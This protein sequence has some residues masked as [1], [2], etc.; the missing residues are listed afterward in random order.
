M[1]VYLGNV[2]LCVCV[3]YV[4]LQ[5][6]LPEAGMW[7]SVAAALLERQQQDTASV[8]TAEGIFTHRD[9][10]IHLLKCMFSLKC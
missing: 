10:M 1:L 5:Y 4:L 6:N 9:F 3:L 2:C 7:V 8:L